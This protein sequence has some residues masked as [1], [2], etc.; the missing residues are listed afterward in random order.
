MVYHYIYIAY[1]Y[2]GLP[3]P[4]RTTAASIGSLTPLPLPQEI[5]V[6][7]LPLHL[8]EIT[9]SHPA[10][11]KIRRPRTRPVSF[12]EKY[13]RVGEGRSSLDQQP[14]IIL[15]PGRLEGRRSVSQQPIRILHLGRLEGRCSRGQRPIIIRLPGRLEI[16][17][18]QAGQPGQRCVPRWSIPWPSCAHSI[19][20]WQPIIIRDADLT[21]TT[22][23]LAAYLN[24]PDPAS[25]RIQPLDLVETPSPDLAS[26]HLLFSNLI[27]TP[28][29]DRPLG[30]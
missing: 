2:C 20:G 18:E 10:A 4:P 21:R 11:R 23:N 3:P 28:S 15:L 8:R 29:L 13:G 17:L 19:P 5:T 1:I 16:S 6:T 27:E 14:I 30:I 24:R 22:L 7:W 9:A 12:R 26:P 25:S